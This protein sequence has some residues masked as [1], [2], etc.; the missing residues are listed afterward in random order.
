[1]MLRPA[2]IDIALARAL[3]RAPQSDAS[4]PPYFWLGAEAEAKT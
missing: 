1:M 4:T 2:P 3:A